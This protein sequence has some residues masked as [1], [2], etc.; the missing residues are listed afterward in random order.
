MGAA[1][2]ERAQSIL[3]LYVAHSR[4]HFGEKRQKKSRK[5]YCFSFVFLERIERRHLFFPLST[6]DKDV[7]ETRFRS[8]QVRKIDLS[9]LKEVFSPFSISFFSGF[10]CDETTSSFL[11]LE[12]VSRKKDDAPPQRFATEAA[13]FPPF[14]TLKLSMCF[15]FFRASLLLP[16]RQTILAAARDASVTFFVSFLDAYP[17]FSR[18]VKKRERGRESFLLFVGCLFSITFHFWKIFFGLFFWLLV[19]DGGNSLSK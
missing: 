17:A 19:F 7:S 12:D 8:S 3:V 6:I 16:T 2:S 15:V 13:T 4:F 10:V 14:S 1:Q 9:N 18:E 11:S 5:R